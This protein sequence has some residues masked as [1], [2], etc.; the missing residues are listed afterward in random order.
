[1]IAFALFFSVAMF[2]WISRVS[3][4]NYV[5]VWSIVLIVFIPIF[6]FTAFICSRGKLEIE[7]ELIKKAL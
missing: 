6:M 4:Y 5:L 3:T 1:M 7:E 2:Y